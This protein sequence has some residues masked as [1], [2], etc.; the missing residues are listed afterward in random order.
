MRERAQEGNVGAWP[1]PRLR[2]GR[3]LPL[4]GRWVGRRNMGTVPLAPAKRQAGM[5]ERRA[6]FTHGHDH[7]GEGDR[8]GAGRVRQRG[9]GAEGDRA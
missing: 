2:G 1:V 3:W 5:G 6:F 9:R 4:A 8:G 7:L